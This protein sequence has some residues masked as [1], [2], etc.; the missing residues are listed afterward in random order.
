MCA[1]AMIP[2]TIKRIALIVWLLENVHK[3]IS[4][5]EAT[6]E[7]HALDYHSTHN[8]LKD[9]ASGGY[10]RITKERRYQVANAPALVSEIALALPLR[11]K[12]IVG[13]FLGGGMLDK[14]RTLSLRE[15]NTVFTLFAAAELLSPYVRTSTVHAYIPQESIEMLTSTMIA[16]GGRRAAVGEADTHLLP[17]QHEFDFLFDFSRKRDSFRIAPMGILLADLQSYGGLGQ[18]QANRIMKQWL[19]GQV[20]S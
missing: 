6:R 2:I 11:Q 1:T 7:A 10:L 5:R 8:A 17:T 18:E 14:M 19:S 12:P 13:F 4:V 20:S 9:F 15:V 3:E 16:S